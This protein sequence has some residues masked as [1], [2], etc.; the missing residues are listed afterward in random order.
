MVG[1]TVKNK[2]RKGIVTKKRLFVDKGRPHG[3][4]VLN[5]HGTPEEEFRYFAEAYRLVA[6]E[7]VVALRKNPHFGLGGFPIDDFRAYPVVFLYRHALELSMKAVILV[8][9]P[10]LSIKDMGQIDRERILSIHYLDELRQNLE[11]I[12]KAYGWKW[13]LGS[14]HF[15]SID[16]FRKIIAELHAVDVLSDTFRYPVNKKGGSPLV[17]HFRFD[18]FEFCEVLD[19]LLT[20]LESASIGAH[21]ELSSPMGNGES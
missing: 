1:P 6:Q 15:R 21:E 14:P 5:W 8:G 9:S 4:V 16:D 10:M 11:R 12:F 18:L 17:S 7:A 2:D 13:D 19:S 3:T 20:A